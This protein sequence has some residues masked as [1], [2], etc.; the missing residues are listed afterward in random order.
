L[1]AFIHAIPQDTANLTYS[2][3]HPIRN[4]KS[5]EREEGPITAQRFCLIQDDDS[6]GQGKPLVL[7]D[8][9]FR[10]IIHLCILAYVGGISIKH[11]GSVRTGI[12]PN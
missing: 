1:A 10:A 11:E 6:F 3:T 5:A 2:L 9:I 8:R 7:T 12:G 4:K